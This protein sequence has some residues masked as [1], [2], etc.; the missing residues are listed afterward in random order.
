[1]IQYLPIILVYNRCMH[2]IDLKKIWKVNTWWC[3][4]TLKMIVDRKNK[5]TQGRRKE[6]SFV[7][8]W[9]NNKCTDVE[10]GM[11]AIGISAHSVAM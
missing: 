5:F 6:N 2:Y 3:T 7:L 1:M 9:N 8:E 4:A 10:N 11:T